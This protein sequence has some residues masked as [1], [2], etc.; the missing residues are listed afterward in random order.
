MALQDRSKLWASAWTAAVV[1]AVGEAIIS[2]PRGAK[3][4]DLGQLHAVRR[5]S[6]KQ[7]RPESI[8]CSSS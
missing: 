5:W 2:P 1:D 6:N 7:R 3:E 4:E 8:R